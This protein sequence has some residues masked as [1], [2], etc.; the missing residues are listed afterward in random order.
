MVHLPRPS[1]LQGG[2]INTNAGGCRFRPSGPPTF[3]HVTDVGLL[4]W[5]QQVSAGQFSGHGSGSWAQQESDG[6]MDIAGICGDYAH[7]LVSP[8]AVFVWCGMF[9]KA[10][11]HVQ[12]QFL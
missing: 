1:A 5:E 9:L 3:G 12:A 7:A 2:G 6:F 8:Q 10:I 4:S 11:L